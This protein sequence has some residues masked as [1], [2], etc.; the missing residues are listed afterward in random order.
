[1]TGGAAAAARTAVRPIAR[2]RTAVE[3]EGPGLDVDATTGTRA[4]GAAGAAGLTRTGLAERAGGA[5][6]SAGAAG[7]MMHRSRALPPP[8]A[9][10]AGDPCPTSLGS[11]AAGT[12]A[13]A[14]RRIGG[15]GGAAAHL[16]TPATEV[17]SAAGPAPAEAARAGLA[18]GPAITAV[19]PLGRRR[20]RHRRR[21]LRPHRRRRGHPCR[22]RRR[23]RQSRRCRRA[24]RSPGW[25]RGCPPPFSVSASPAGR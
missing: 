4:A 7:R 9:A 17:Q 10:R 2:D 1:M 18:C 25:R 22:R 5:A 12:A 13:A 19:A 6:R 24:R 11:E 14:G 15:E 8:P 16:D 20:R 21:P 3:G 23:S